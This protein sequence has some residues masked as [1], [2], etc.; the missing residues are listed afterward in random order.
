V[1]LAFEIGIRSRWRQDRIGADFDSHFARER[2]LGKWIFDKNIVDNLEQCRQFLLAGD[3]G[4]TTMVDF[5]QP[6]KYMNQTTTED[7][8]IYST[9]RFAVQGHNT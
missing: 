7:G 8:W 2:E 3:P 9:M 4:I 6:K 1:S 5:I